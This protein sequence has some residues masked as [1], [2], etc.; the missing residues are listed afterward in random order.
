LGKVKGEPE[1]TV[2]L[3]EEPILKEK[4]EDLEKLWIDS[5]VNTL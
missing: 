1:L 4:I 5:L 3:Y 2:E